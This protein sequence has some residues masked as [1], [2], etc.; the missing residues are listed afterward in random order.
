MDIWL[1]VTKLVDSCCLTSNIFQLAVPPA[2]WPG[3][4]TLSLTVTPFMKSC[5]KEDKNLRFPLIFLNLFWSSIDSIFLLLVVDG[6]WSTLLPGDALHQAV[7]ASEGSCSVTGGSTA[8][9]PALNPSTKPL[10]DSPAAA[11]LHSQSRT[12][13]MTPAFPQWQV[14]WNWTMN[15]LYL[16]IPLFSSFSWQ[17]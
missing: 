6:Y 9:C 1:Q 11:H 5:R 10:A 13:G 15:L 2:D 16:W 17:L 12:R 7:N 8:L 14:N 4:K 3:H